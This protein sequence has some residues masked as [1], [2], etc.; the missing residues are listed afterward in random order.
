LQGV[1]HL[2][3]F[4]GHGEELRETIRRRMRMARTVVDR[5]FFG[6]APTR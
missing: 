1:A 6:E 5:V 4:E 2:L 3:G